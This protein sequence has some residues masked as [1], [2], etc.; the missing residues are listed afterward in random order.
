M[1]Q[2]LCKRS[3]SQDGSGSYHLLEKKGFGFMSSHWLR[4][5]VKIKVEMR[6]MIEVFDHASSTA[7]IVEGRKEL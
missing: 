7:L 2:G 5:K 3:I 4:K 1:S 6:M